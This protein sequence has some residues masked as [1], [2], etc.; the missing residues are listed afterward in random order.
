ML[1]YAHYGYSYLAE[2][3]VACYVYMLRQCDQCVSD[4][5]ITQG[6]LAINYYS[7]VYFASY[8]FIFPYLCVTIGTKN[9]RVNNML[10]LSL[11]VGYIIM[12]ASSC[13]PPPH[14]IGMSRIAR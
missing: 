1:Y 10:S 4:H 5:V 8:T 12:Y 7:I 3:K 11:T 9:G 2:R 14:Y 13:D 6:Q